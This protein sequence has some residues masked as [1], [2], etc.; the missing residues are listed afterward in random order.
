[1]SNGG[2]CIGNR[3]P[4]AAGLAGLVAAALLVAGSSASATVISAAAGTNAGCALQSQGGRI[5]HVINQRRLPH[6]TAVI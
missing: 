1:M 3:R 5:Q 4:V 2:V 6:L